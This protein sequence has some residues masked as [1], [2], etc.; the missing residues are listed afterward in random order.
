MKYV[1]FQDEKG[2]LY[3]VLFD[4][5]LTHSLVAVEGCKAVSAGFVDDVGGVFG[6][7]ESLKLE[8]NWERDSAYVCAALLNDTSTLNYMRV[9]DMVEKG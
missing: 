9:M 1:M 7:S 3:P 4:D 2:V 5:H 6:K 8:S